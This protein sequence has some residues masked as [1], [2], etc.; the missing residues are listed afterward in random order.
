LYK[1]TSLSLKKDSEVAK[2]ARK[3]KPP[4]SLVEFELLKQAGLLA[5]ASKL[6]PAFPYSGGIPGG[7][8]LLQRR[9]RGGFSPLFP[10]HRLVIHW[11][12]ADTC[13]INLFNF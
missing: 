11:I 3:N 7:T 2:K 8:L 13:F 12:T 1:K 4:P 9:D 5:Q 10:F 6:P